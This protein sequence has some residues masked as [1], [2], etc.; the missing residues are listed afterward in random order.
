MTKTRNVFTVVGLVTFS[1]VE[2]LLLGL[3]AHD[4]LIGWARTFSWLS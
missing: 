1:T 2:V 4:L 3:W